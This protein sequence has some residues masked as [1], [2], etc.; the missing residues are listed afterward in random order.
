MSLVKF[1]GHYPEMFRK[2]PTLKKDVLR[3]FRD[4]RRVY[5]KK[6]P[7]IVKAMYEGEEIPEDIRPQESSS[8]ESKE[9]LRPSRV[10]EPEYNLFESEADRN[11]NDEMEFKIAQIRYRQYISESSTLLE[12]EDIDRMVR[13]FC[14]AYVAAYKKEMYDIGTDIV[15]A[16]YDS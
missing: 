9:S 3:F 16:V 11:S 13:D 2:T 8:E 15:P 7:E 14:K 5:F 10:I 1:Y 12:P 4:D 6:M